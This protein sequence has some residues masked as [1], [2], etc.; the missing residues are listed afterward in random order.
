MILIANLIIHGVF[1]GHC[2]SLA[3]TSS[4]GDCFL[5][6]RHCIEFSMST[7]AEKLFLKVIYYT[8]DSATV[9]TLNLNL[10][11]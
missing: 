11:C 9:Q 10:K 7:N 4:S 1:Q 2:S 8:H 5:V 3:S 6:A